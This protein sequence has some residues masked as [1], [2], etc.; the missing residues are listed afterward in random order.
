M[1][2]NFNP[3]DETKKID[4]RKNKLSGIIFARAISCIGIII[5]HYFCY[6]KGKFKILFS[7]ANSSY[8]FMFVTLFFCI[9]GV[10]LYYNYPKINSIKN[11]YYKRWKSILFPFYICYLYFFYHKICNQRILFY[12]V[13]WRIFF[14]TLIGLDGYLS[15]MT[16]TYYLVGEWFL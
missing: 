14:I 9:S 7:T 11:F 6:S 1:R 12:K 5:Y 8:G 4:K 3:I 13:N 16:K 15:S 2:I 10:V